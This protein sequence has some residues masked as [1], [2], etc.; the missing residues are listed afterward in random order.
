MNLLVIDSLETEVLQWL[1]TRHSLQFAPELAQNPEALRHALRD[2][3]ALIAP[4]SV[5]LDASLLYHAPLL[6]SIGLV[7]GNAE[8]ID[9][10][11]CDRAGIEI[12]RSHTATARAEAEFMMGAVLALFRQTTPIQDAYFSARELGSATVGLFGMAPAARAMAKM[13]ASFGSRVVG[14]DPT[15]H[16]RHEA[17]AR[18]RIQP[19]GLYDLLGQAD[20]VCVQ[21]TCFSRYRGLFG[22]RLL[23]TCKPGQVMVCVGHSDL[24]DA[25]ALAHALKTGR[26]AAAWL[27]HA[28]PSALQ[29]PSPLAG[30]SNLHVTS[31]LAT[32]TREA[33]LRSAWAVAK[34][35]DELF[36]SDAA[37]AAWAQSEDA[38]RAA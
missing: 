16:A 22:E 8:N 14:Y 36:V 32:A 31:R 11:L 17:W 3:Q 9:L 19:L 30:L 35:I 33:H 28:N 23:S 7:R 6:R 4:A 5:R 34:R 21:L 38:K 26:L 24:F 10:D 1:E 15:V 37:E 13:L 2:V 27:D 25:Q 18:W 12:I 29:A 20:A